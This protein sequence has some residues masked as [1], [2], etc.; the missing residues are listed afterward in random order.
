MLGLTSY[1]YNNYATPTRSKMTPFAHATTHL[2]F[3][4]SRKAQHNG[5]QDNPHIRGFFF[6]LSLSR[7]EGGNWKENVKKSPKTHLLDP[8][9]SQLEEPT[10]RESN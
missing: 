10:D 4:I 8:L 3:R 5:I 1:A 2:T 7:K 6:S 9:R